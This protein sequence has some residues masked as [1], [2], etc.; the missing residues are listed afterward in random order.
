MLDP[1]GK[2]SQAETHDIPYSISSS[3]IVIILIFS[4][5]EIMIHGDR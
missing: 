2:F 4:P 3:H 1:S 5:F